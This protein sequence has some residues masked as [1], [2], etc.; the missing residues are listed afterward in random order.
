MALTVYRRNAYDDVALLA[1]TDLVASDWQLEV[2]SAEAHEWGPVAAVIMDSH[3][4]WST[5]DLSRWE[6]LRRGD[7]TALHETFPAASRVV[8]VGVPLAVMWNI[9][10]WYSWQNPRA[11]RAFRFR[12][13]DP[14]GAHFEFS[15]NDLV[16][17][18]EHVFG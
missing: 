8:P 5:P 4:N 6:A 12:F 17:E 13:T 3:M 15:H 11:E 7:P 9:S 16:R 10:S 1:S 2:E 18:R 14:R